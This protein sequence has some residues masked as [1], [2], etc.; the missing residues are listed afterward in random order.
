[1]ARPD[2]TAFAWLL[3]AFLFMESRPGS[4]RAAGAGV[5][6]TFAFLC[7]QSTLPA[8]LA[9]AIGLVSRSRRDALVFGATL[10]VGVGVSTALFDASSDGWVPLVR[11]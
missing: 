5:L 8:S 1:M 10:L 6:A 9:L 4:S 3:A 11:L 7:K 2:A